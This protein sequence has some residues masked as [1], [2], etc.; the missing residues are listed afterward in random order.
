MEGE[1]KSGSGLAVVLGVILVLA[2][3][4]VAWFFMQGKQEAAPMP[5]P[6]VETGTPE[7]TPEAGSPEAR[8]PANAGDVDA[9][10]ASLVA[11]ADADTA[12]MASTDADVSLVGTDGQAVS[13][14]N[15]TYDS[16]AF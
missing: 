13:D 6:V 5:A 9:M 15:T 8:V 4:G 12:A 1:Q 11:E 16:T 14:F 2:L 3:I 10:V 7:A